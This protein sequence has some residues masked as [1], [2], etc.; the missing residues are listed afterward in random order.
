MTLQAVTP[1]YNVSLHTEA[2]P[3]QETT[4]SQE[5][6]KKVGDSPTS[7]NDE[8]KSKDYETTF[9]TRSFITRY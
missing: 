4:K 1:R 9:I 2:D 7:Q 3:D 6:E 8:K 5:E